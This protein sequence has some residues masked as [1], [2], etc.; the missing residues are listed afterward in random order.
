MPRR[1]L[2]LALITM[3][4]L[5]AVGPQTARAQIFDPFSD[6]FELYYGFFIPRQAAEAARIRPSDAINQR[7]VNRSQQILAERDLLYNPVS[8]FIPTAPFTPEME[9]RT[10]VAVPRVPGLTSDNTNGLG[11]PG[12]FSRVTSRES[13]F[14]YFPDY[15][16]SSRAAGAAPRQGGTTAAGFGTGGLGRAAQQGANQAIQGLIPNFGA[17]R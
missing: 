6:P 15:P 2:I 14:P 9:S 10:P 7:N 16:S 17:P 5:L 11:P 4:L 8:P 1:I 3:G 12:Y 13:S